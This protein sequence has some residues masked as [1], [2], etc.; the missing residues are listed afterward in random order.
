MAKQKNQNGLIFIPDISGF[1]KFVNDTEIEHS[2]HII[3]ELLEVIIDANMINLQVSEI[4]GDA[5]LF[6]RF[7]N[8]PTAYDIAE[9][10]KQMFIEFHKYLQIIERDRVCHCGACSTASQLTIKM[11]VHFGEVRIS[12]IKGHKKLIGKTVIVAHRL[13]KNDISGDEYLLMT[14]EYFSKLQVGESESQ[15]NWDAVHKTSTDYEHL[16]ELTYYYILLSDL[17]NF[18]PLVEPVA[19][20]QTF[21]DP[22]KVE[23]QINAPMSFIYM[24]IIDLDKRVL[25]LDGLKKIDYNKES[26]HRIGTRH[27]CDLPGGKVELQTILSEED[28]KSISYAEKAEGSFIFPGA[29][30]FF[31]LMDRD[32]GTI[33]RLEFHYHRRKILGEMIDRIFRKKLAIGLAKSAKNLKELCESEYQA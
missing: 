3:S 26:L 29:T 16:G 20:P 30:T 27:M 7:G 21:P 1:T 11:L 18:I 15:F 25:W 14:E 33:F 12:D 28:E 9:Q 24:I 2:Q 19:K 32:L 5:V 8:A 23:I 22:I 13:L 10:S 4:E 31:R 6:Y 17:R